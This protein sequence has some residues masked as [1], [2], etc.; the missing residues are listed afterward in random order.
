MQAFR[1][2]S[3]IGLTLLLEIDW[4]TVRK[5]EAPILQSLGAEDTMTKKECLSACIEKLEE[6][7]GQETFFLNEIGQSTF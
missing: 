6:E 1:S 7:S 2:I 5:S 3:V 4:T